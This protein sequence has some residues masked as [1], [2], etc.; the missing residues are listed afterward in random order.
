MPSRVLRYAYPLPRRPS[1]VGAAMFHS[2]EDE[3]RREDER[4]IVTLARAW[5]EA[6]ERERDGA[7]ARATLDLLASAVEAY[8]RNNKPGPERQ[9]RL[10]P[11]VYQRGLT[12]T[13]DPLQED[14]PA[15]KGVAAALGKAAAVGRTQDAR[16]ALARTGCLCTFAQSVV[17]DGCSVCNP[18]LAAQVAADN[19]QDAAADERQEG[20]GT[21]NGDA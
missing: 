2:W 8:E 9:P 17:G 18:E 6:D 4:T 5:Y 3:G 10:D 16:E 19:A 12:V 11:L 14:R 15:T 1:K 7:T 21:G 20:T 13:Y